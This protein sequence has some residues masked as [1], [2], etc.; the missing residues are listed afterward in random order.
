MNSE[1]A[2]KGYCRAQTLPGPDGSIAAWVVGLTS[3]CGHGTL[4]CHPKRVDRIESGG[5]QNRAVVDSRRA[6]LWVQPS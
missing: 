1:R 6:S 2:G 5:A 4:L 3:L